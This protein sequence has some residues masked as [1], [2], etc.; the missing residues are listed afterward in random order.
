MP[1]ISLI[2]FLRLKFPY[3]FDHQT[4]EFFLMLN[5]SLSLKILLEDLFP[6]AYL[7]EINPFCSSTPD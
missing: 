2:F 3:L 6:K 5:S 1:W 4:L 7:K